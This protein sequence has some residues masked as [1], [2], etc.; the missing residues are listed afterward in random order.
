M[1]AIKRTLTERDF[2]GKVL[3]RHPRWRQRR[4]SKD[5]GQYAHVILKAA[6]A[7]VERALRFAV[8]S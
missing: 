5:D 8:C 1:R 3:S 4:P 2:N 7:A 6:S